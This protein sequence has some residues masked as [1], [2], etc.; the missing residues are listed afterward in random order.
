MW[1]LTEILET[2]CEIN[3][4]GIHSKIEPY[5]RVTTFKTQQDLAKHLLL[6]DYEW[7]TEVHIEYKKGE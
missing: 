3:E 1:E 6:L 7:I 2:P 5:K 4:Q